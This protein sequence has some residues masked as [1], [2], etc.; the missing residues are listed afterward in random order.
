MPL[1]V[2]SNVAARAR[3]LLR[4]IQRW[5]PLEVTMAW[6]VSRAL[7]ILIALAA[8]DQSPRLHAGG[9]FAQNI[10]DRLADVL[11]RWDGGWYHRVVVHGYMNDDGTAS[12]AVA[13]FPLYPLAIRAAV[14]AFRLPDVWLATLLSNLCA[15]LAG[16]LLHRLIEREFGT[17]VALWGTLFFFFAPS[18][19][20]LSAYYTESFFLMLSLGCYLCAV[21]G[22]WWCMAFLGALTTATRPTGF[23]L[24]GAVFIN[25]WQ[26]RGFRRMS[27]REVSVP[28][29]AMAASSTGAI[30][31]AAYLHRT[32]GTVNVYFVAQSTTWPRKFQLSTFF[33]ML[34]DIEKLVATSTE[35]LLQ[36]FIPAILGLVGVL[37]LVHLRRLGDA[38]LVLGTLVLAIGGGTFES[39]QRYMLSLFPL[40]A[41]LAQIPA[42]S[43][44]GVL[45]AASACLMGYWA[46]LFGGGWHFT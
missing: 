27:L 39:T 35:A 24:I 3:I 22:K 11:S 41:L 21:R 2:L 46:A 37:W 15:L 6:L 31:Y 16:V 14:S 20:H 45:L 26:A 32:F 25:Y 4:A 17:A 40:Y 28:M 13:F 33:R 8:T 18:S 9:M 7:A 34:T 10:V 30:A 38:L 23:L 42:T 12:P 19:I 1:R 5:F 43:A 44:K 29:L 36:G